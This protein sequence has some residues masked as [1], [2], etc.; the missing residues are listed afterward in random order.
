MQEQQP[1]DA[2]DTVVPPN[3]FFKG[4]L[5]WCL[6][7]H[8]PNV[9]GAM[10]KSSLF[11]EGKVPTSY[12]RKTSSRGT[13]KASNRAKGGANL[14]TTSLSDSRS[15]KKREI[16]EESTTSGQSL[17][18]E[19]NKDEDKDAIIM[20]QTVQFFHSEFLEKELQKR[21][22]LQIRIV[23]DEI[24]STIRRCDRLTD[25]YYRMKKGPEA[26]EVKTSIDNYEA[27]ILDLESKLKELQEAEVKRR[28][29]MLDVMK[30]QHFDTEEEMDNHMAFK[31]LLG[32]QEAYQADISELQ[33]KVNMLEQEQG[34]AQTDSTTTGPAV[35]VEC[36]VT[37]TS[38]RCRKCKRNICA[39]CCKEKRDLEMIWWCE[40]CFEAESVTNQ[41]QIR[42]G[43]YE[44][45]GEETFVSF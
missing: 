35:C 13:I 31:V 11:T 41:Q 10:M 42:D 6:W 40:D 39:I 21:N 22:Y 30:H 9:G 45:D 37:P 12:G 8:L 36:S 7:G 29:E 4:F 26:Q 16:P 32:N 33:S 5:A 20:A 34:N 38:H 27:E 28:D 15:A 43:K 3:Y 24:A 14:L 18:D 2:L 44:S 17:A 19:T 1:I 25:K 23:K